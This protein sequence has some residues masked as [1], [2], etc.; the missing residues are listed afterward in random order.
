MNVTKPSCAGTLES[1]D[2]F[3]EVQPCTDGLSIDIESVVLLQ[4]GPSLQ[5]TVRNVLRNNNVTQ[6]RIKLKD[7]GALDC[8]VR[9]RVETALV[10]AAEEVAT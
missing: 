6:A 8:T 3:V 1:S 7:R 10:R 2:V 4:F 9:A 5:E